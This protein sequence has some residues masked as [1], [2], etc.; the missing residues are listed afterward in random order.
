MCH[1]NLFVGVLIPV[2][3]YLEVWP[4]RVRLDEFMR[5]DLSGLVLSDGEDKSLK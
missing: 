3:W 5:V 4:L 2:S 1:Q